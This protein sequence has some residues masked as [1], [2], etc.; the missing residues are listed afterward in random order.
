MVL[1]DEDVVRESFVD[2]FEDNLWD[3]I[4]ANSGEEALAQLKDGSPDAAIVDVRL[5]GMDGH[6]FIREAY[7]QK[8]NMVFVVCTGSPEYSLPENFKNLPR[9]SNRLFKKPVTDLKE[10]E[11]E[12][13][14]LIQII[15]KN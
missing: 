1:D 14:S 15:D 11:D 6:S 5:G 10:I 8:K 2:Y 7:N 3:A 4:Q 12:I 13:L 9:V